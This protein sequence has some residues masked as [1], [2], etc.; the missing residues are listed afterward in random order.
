VLAGERFPLPDTVDCT[1]PLV[2][3]TVRERTVV[4]DEVVPTTRTAA[5]TL[6]TA[7]APRPMVSGDR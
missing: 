1:T 3:V 2:T 4:P 6:P 5:T 7:S